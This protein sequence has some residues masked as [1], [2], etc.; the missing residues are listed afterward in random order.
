MKKNFYKISVVIIFLLTAIK[1]KSQVTLF[2]E[3]WTSSSFSTNNWTFPNGQGNWAVGFSYTPYG[4]NPPNAYFDWA[5]TVTNYTYSLLSPTINATSYAGQV[6]SMDYLLELNNFSTA[7]VEQFI[8]EYK[9]IAASTWSTV[10]VYVNN[11]PGVTD[12][13]V[14]NAVLAGMGGQNFQVRF[15]AFGANSFNINGWGLDSIV[16]KAASCPTVAPAISTAA[17][18][19]ISCSGSPVVLTAMGANTYTWNPGNI[20]GSSFT[21]TPSS[22]TT[23]TV[24]GTLTGCTVVPLPASIS[25]STTPSPSVSITGISALCAGQSGT[26]A[27]AGAQTYSWIPS[28][29][30][31]S[32][33]S[34]SV[35]ATPSSST[36]YTVIGTASNGCTNIAS[37][38]VTINQPPT[39]LSLTAT[40][41][42]ICPVG[43]NS[44][45]NV[46]AAMTSN[47]SVTPITYSPIPTPAGATTLCMGGSAVTV[48]TNGTL[49][50]GDWENITLPF[51][52]NF[53][54][55][56]YNSFAVG[57]NGFFFPGAIPNTYT[58]YGT[59][60]PDPFSTT[61]CIAPMYADLDFSGTGTIEY[62]TV[63][64]SPNQKLV[65]NWSGGEYYPTTGSM[66]L[67]LIIYETSNIIEV[68]TS[69]A[70]GNNSEIEAI[71]DGTGTNYL[72]VPGRNGTNYTVSTPDAY[73]FAP[74]VGTPTYSWVPS[75][76]L[77]SSSVSNPTATN[78]TSSV[79]Y[80][81][82]ATILGCSTTGT[83]SLSVGGPPA[84]NIVATPSALCS[85]SGTSNIVAS[86]VGTYSWSTG[87]S[88]SSISVSPTVTT[89]YTV[90]GYNNPGCTSTQTISIA[91][92]A[93]PNLSISAGSGTICAGGSTG[94]TAN[95]AT[96]YTWNTGSNASAIAVTP[97]ATTVYTVSGSNGNGCANSA[98][99]SIFVNS[100]PTVNISAAQSTVCV[101][102]STVALSGSPAGGV[103][104]GTNVSGN[105]FTPGANAGTFTPGYN[106]TSTVTGCSNTAFTTIVVSTCT[107]FDSKVSSLA[108][109]AVYPNPTNGELTIEL[110]N[111]AAKSI[112]LA[113]LT[114]R[115]IYSE[116][117]FKDKTSLNLAA[118]A[119]GVYFVKIKSA[120]QTEIIKVIK[121]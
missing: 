25:I 35:I 105:V 94:L 45:L 14:T 52:F 26:M 83:L 61:P 87:S 62:F 96:S 84:I 100:L 57:T 39:I 47:Y 115:V 1:G 116:S 109:L 22:N 68:H 88:S 48:L 67:Q 9:D 27:A 121:Q 74:I 34:A 2:T 17:S 6:I 71:Q 102:G 43:G 4:I 106:V 23:Y 36:N 97:S 41:N 80:S 108:G 120:E 49:D 29:G 90:T 42:V 86:G 11:I 24:S 32:G 40:P 118:F 13:S 110:N 64:V 99:V 79:L 98:T 119:N 72:D 76:Y 55:T 85:G 101:N 8:I 21:V 18:S 28:S 78:V 46:S 7:T 60:F 66:G 92:G 77:S 117:T 89:T 16:I 20:S 56:S 30:L 91:V 93:A 58:G 37:H 38:Q 10:N 73:R 44:Q 65:V 5:P 33:T 54:G 107:G 112:E 82:T 15:T 50:D 19:T 31:N 103:Y 53:Y 70:T 81:V 59:S 75:T 63:G 113:D 111:G 114:G 3:D 51:T 69:N 12:Y 95:G 104:T